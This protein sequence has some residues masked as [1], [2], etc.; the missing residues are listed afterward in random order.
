MNTE[1]EVTDIVVSPS[2]KLSITGNDLIEE[3][4]NETD[5]DKVEDLTNLFKI[6]Q[7]KRNLA[8]INKLS[9]LLDTIDKEVI[10]RLNNSPETF[11]NE[12]LLAYMESTQKSINNI[13]QSVDQVPLIQINN[14][15][16]EINIANSSGLNR[17]S[18]QKVL[19][20]VMAILNNETEE[21]KDKDIIDITPSEGDNN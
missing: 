2:N 18:R 9:N 5:S 14:Q 3:I 17:E 11:R 21:A 8:R 4:I 19:D 15:K 7:K 16:N 12:T 20:T 1:E 13:E 10:E 6:N